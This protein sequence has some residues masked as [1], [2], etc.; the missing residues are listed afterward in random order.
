MFSPL[1]TIDEVSAHYNR[2]SRCNN[3]LEFSF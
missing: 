2:N 1:K 3:D